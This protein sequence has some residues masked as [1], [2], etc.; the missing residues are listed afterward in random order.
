MAWPSP[1]DD[2]VSAFSPPS[3]GAENLSCQLLIAGGGI[4]GLSAAE[5]AMRQGLDVIV[6]EKGVFGQES[7]S[8]LNA[9]QFLTGWVKPVATMISELTQQE[10]ERG[11]RGE[12]PRSRAQRRVRA[13][14]RRTV[15]GCERLD[16]L[17][18]DY[19]LRACVQRGAAIAAVSDADLASLK[20]SY[21]F[22]KTCNLSGISSPARRGQRSL[23]RALS[24]EQFQKRCGTAEDFY[25]GGI[26]DFVGGSFRPRKFLHGLAR[27]LSERGVRFFQNTEAQALDFS[28]DSMTVFCGN[29]AAIR[30]HTLLMAN[31]YARHINGD[32]HER[33]IFVYDYV[34]EVD[35]A[36]SAGILPSENVL[37]DTRDPCFYARRDGQR[38]YMGYEETAETS[39]E[40]TR[41]VARR[42]LREGQRVFPALRTV[43]EHDIRNAWS[44]AIYYTLD[45]YPFVERR[46]G[47]RLITFAAPSDHGNS[48]AARVGQIV[49][50]LAAA[51][52]AHAQGESD[53]RHR[54]RESQKLRLFEDFPK[55]VRLRPGMRYQE[56]TSPGPAASTADES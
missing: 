27:S 17:D 32:I 55:G 36:E 51:S 30:A 48:L 33:T 56:A 35:L 31:A 15:E 12:L 6:V 40:I 13:F 18:R 19:N 8:S 26:I 14:L 41:D 7:A 23:F 21:D 3:S 45:D 24:A 53:S 9:G 42:T 16:Q 44:G 2:N 50:D 11:V 25:A 29:G 54:R 37:S 39:P 46:H 10:Q 20:A 34:V 38:L 22:M 4:C 49:G 28:D 5:A 1:Y 47:G 52:I 43:T